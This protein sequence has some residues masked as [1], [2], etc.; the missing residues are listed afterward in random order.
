MT[1][2][3]VGAGLLLS[4]TPG[5]PDVLE[6]D[7]D[8]VNGG[9][10]WRLLTGQLVHWTAR[11]TLI[12]LGVILL[13]GAWL[14]TYSRKLLLLS[15][16]SAPIVIGA[17]LHLLPSGLDI[18]RG[19]SGLATALFVCMAFVLLRGKRRG[20]AL[21]ALMMMMAKIVWELWSGSP[22]AA[23]DL[24]NGVEVAPLAHLLGAVAGLFAFIV[25]RRSK[26]LHH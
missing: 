15:L 11:M 7:R 8:A 5:L 26:P 13:L 19:S 22:I 18:Y 6:Y 10:I 1:L 16:A 9:Q 25:C 20:F 4:F 24:P 2:A 3:L 12:D 17:G 14:E 23:G 21:L